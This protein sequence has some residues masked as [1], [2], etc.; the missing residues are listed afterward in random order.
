M[1][2]NIVASISHIIYRNEL[3]DISGFWGLGTGVAACD[4]KGI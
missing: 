2:K 3:I 1:C 4:S